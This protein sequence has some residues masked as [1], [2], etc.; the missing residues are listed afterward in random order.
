[1]ILPSILPIGFDESCIRRFSRS[2]QI[3]KDES[4]E[5]PGK[6]GNQKMWG[7]KLQLKFDCDMPLP[8]PLLVSCKG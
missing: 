6:F 7:M 1:M 2:W 8:C 4:E 5:A 3:G